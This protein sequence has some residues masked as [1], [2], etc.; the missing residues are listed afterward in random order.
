M[1]HIAV[2]QLYRSENVDDALTDTFIKG[3]CYKR[4][5]EPV[6]MVPRRDVWWHE[7]VAKMSGVVRHNPRRRTSAV[8]VV[9]ERH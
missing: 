7:F 6:T 5:S 9:Y 4:T 2:E 3:H 8:H 1:A